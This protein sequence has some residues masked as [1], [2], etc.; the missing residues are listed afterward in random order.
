[1]AHEYDR[2]FRGNQPQD[3]EA[4]RGLAGT[5]F[6]DHAE[7]LAFAHVDADAVDRLD[8]A[9]HLAQQAALDWKPDFEVGRFQHERRVGLRRGGIG[10]RLGGKQRPGIGMRRRRK[11]ALDV[12][13]LDDLAFLHHANLLRDLA[14]DAEVVGDE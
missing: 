9:D 11:Y 13:L 5:G 2:P 10:L 8:M 1:M 12:A 4:E 3:G 6:A 14:H 7:R